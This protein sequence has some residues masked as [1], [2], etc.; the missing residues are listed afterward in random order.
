MPIDPILIVDD[1]RELTAVINGRLKKPKPLSTVL[2]SGVMSKNLVTEGVQVETLTGAY[3]MAPFVSKNGKASP[4]TRGNFEAYTIETPCIKIQAP[5]SDSDQLL[6]RKAG[7]LNFAADTDIMRVNALETLIEDA[8]TMNEM[9]AL[10]EE[11][12]WSQWLTGTIAYENADSNT[13]WSIDTKKPGANTFTA[14]PLWS[15]QNALIIADM[16]TV[17][18]I[19]QNDHQGPAPKIGLCGKNAAATLNMRIE[20]GWVTAIKT[21]SG[22]LA[23]NAQLVAEYDELG[24]SYIG[25][26]GGVSFWEVSGTLTDDAGVTTPIIREDYIEFFSNGPTAKADRTK[27][28]GRKR[29]ITAMFEE[30]AIGEKSARAWIDEDA[31]AYIQEVQTR[32]FFWAKHPQWY[33]SLKVI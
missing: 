1:I 28:Y 7:T 24:M 18:G 5:L 4:I 22:V 11:W 10:R 20:K 32:P 16:K 15:D 21:D 9:I 31:D 33:V 30:T 6:Q 12:L 13:K 2:G 23:G 14:N 3:E 25:L 29:G 27:F 8:D 26:I 19:I 17:A